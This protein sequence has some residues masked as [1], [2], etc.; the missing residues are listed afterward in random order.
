VILC[1]SQCIMSGGTDFLLVAK[2]NFDPL[3]RWC[4]PG[5]FLQGKYIIIMYFGGR[6]FDTM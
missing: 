3:L 5:F 4:P 6:H 1:P 2:V